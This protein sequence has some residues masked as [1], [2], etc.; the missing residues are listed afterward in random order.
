MIPNEF[1][2]KTENIAFDI[3]ARFKDESK[4]VISVD[5]YAASG[6][7]TFSAYLGELLNADVIHTD[8][9]F[10]P[11]ELKTPERLNEPGG[12]IHYERFKEQVIDNLKKNKAFAYDKYNCKNPKEKKSGFFMNRKFTIIEGAYSF[13]PYFGEYAD[14]KIFIKCSFDEQK[15]RILNRNGEEM[16][17]K[18]TEMWI[19]MEMKYF[20]EFDIEEKADTVFRI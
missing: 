6:K 15:A 20:K 8:D 12:N 7:T 16:L 3:F 17:K 4:V 18:F 5:G 14:Y 19:P 1:K 9:F 13:H 11:A 2:E 10:L